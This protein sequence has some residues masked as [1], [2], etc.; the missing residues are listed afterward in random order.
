MFRWSAVK[1]LRSC[2]RIRPHCVLII[3][4]GVGNGFDESADG[5]GAVALVAVNVVA[6]V[7][8][9]DEGGY[10]P[11]VVVVGLA[12]AIGVC[13]FLV[14]VPLREGGGMAK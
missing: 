14:T 4:G 3:S 2:N 5:V 9:D 7:A 8:V 1:I 12:E 13:L 10:I 11:A 6:V